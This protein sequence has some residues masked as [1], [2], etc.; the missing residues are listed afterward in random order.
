VN[1][2]EPRTARRRARAGKMSDP[3]G[4]AAMIEIAQNYERLAERALERIIDEGSR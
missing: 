1:Y 2:R 3:Q 4:K